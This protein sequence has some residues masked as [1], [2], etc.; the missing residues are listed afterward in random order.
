MTVN[1]GY[2]ELISFDSI[3]LFFEV[4]LRQLN[5]PTIRIAEQASLGVDVLN[6]EMGLILTFFHNVNPMLIK[7]AMTRK[8]VNA[9]TRPLKP[10]ESMELAS[11]SYAVVSVPSGNTISHYDKLYEAC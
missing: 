3:A 1:D 9:L 6:W 2:E 8:T 11:S 7:Y 5:A 4:S 10:G